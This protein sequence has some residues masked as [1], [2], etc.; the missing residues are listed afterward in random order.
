MEKGVTMLTKTA[1]RR[2]G[3]ILVDLGYVQDMDIAKALE[4]QA[5][6]PA[7][8]IGRILVEMD[9]LTD[10]QVFQAIELQWDDWLKGNAA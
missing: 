8:K 9:C 1:T 7:K 10:Q 3:E 4:F 5:H 6:N 2:L